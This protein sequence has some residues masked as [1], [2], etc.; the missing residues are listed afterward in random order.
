M[1]EIPVDSILDVDEARRLAGQ[2]TLKKVLKIEFTNSLGNKDAI[3]IGVKDL[4]QW[5][6]VI[7]TAIA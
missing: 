3:A 5:K 2:S 6:K 7:G 4:P 1:L